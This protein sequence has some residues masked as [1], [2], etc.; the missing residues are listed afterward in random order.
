VHYHPTLIAIIAPD[1]RH[2]SRP[3]HLHQ[4]SSSQP[5]CVLL[6]SLLSILASHFF[7]ALSCRTIR[8]DEKQTE[9][10][11]ANNIYRSLAPPSTAPTDPSSHL[12]PQ[13][14]LPHAG[15]YF[16]LRAQTLLRLCRSSHWILALLLS[17]IAGCNRPLLHLVC[18]PSMAPYSYS[19]VSCSIA[20]P[21]SPALGPF[22]PTVH[23]FASLILL[24][25]PVPQLDS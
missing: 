15:N 21:D 11:V 24:V 23:G 1:K 17:L 9:T 19:L 18:A 12:L 7:L 22:P 13:G 2:H 25:V 16:V 10:D 4:S 8:D 5:E 6:R 20:Q 3:C 14:W